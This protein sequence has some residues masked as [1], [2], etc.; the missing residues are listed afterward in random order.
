[1]IVKTSSDW[2][3]PIAFAVAAAAVWGMTEVGSE[4]P[5]HAEKLALVYMLLAVVMG[6][7][8]LRG[9]KVPDGSQYA[10][11]GD[12]GM[13][14]FA[15]PGGTV[16]L[17]FAGNLLLHT[18]A[19]TLD[20]APILPLANS[21]AF[22]FLAYMALMHRRMVALTG[23]HVTTRVG[24]PWPWCARAYATSGFTK[25]AVVANREYMGT[26]G[27]ITSWRRMWYV[28]ALAQNRRVTVG[29]EMSWEAA[30]DRMQEIAKVT[31]I[32]ASTMPPKP[33]APDESQNVSA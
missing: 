27:M 31:G 1:M 15:V 11:W 33:N 18:V 3:A 17:V 9:T 28:V 22:F 24:R 8:A 6:I 32:K 30:R 26:I 29:K 13:D 4:V 20:I 16:L 19:G 7:G 10:W 21:V 2:A 23:E 14:W 25:L 12:V 5:P